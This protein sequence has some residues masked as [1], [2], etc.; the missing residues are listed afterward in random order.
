MIDAL[1]LP[2]TIF[3]VAYAVVCAVAA[4]WVGRRWPQ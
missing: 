4:L 2:G 1:G 3:A